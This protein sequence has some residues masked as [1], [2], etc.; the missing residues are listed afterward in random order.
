MVFVNFLIQSTVAMVILWAIIS[1]IAKFA[2][3]LPPKEEDK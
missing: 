3:K 1:I 2:I